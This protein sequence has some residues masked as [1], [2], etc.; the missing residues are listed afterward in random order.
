[1]N[2]QPK[3]SIVSPSYNQGIFIEAAI[4][5]VLDQKYPNFEHIII[6]GGSTDD[7]LK[8]LK[9][10]PHLIWVSEPDEGQSDAINK[11]FRLATGKYIGWLNVDDYYLPGTFSSVINAF[12]SDNSIDA[13][14]SNYRI[15][16]ARS[17]ISRELYTQN[18][19]KWMSLFYCHIPSTTL[20]FSRKIL[21][22]H[23]LIDKYFDIAM[24]MEFIAHMLYSG[25]K[26]KKINSCFAHFRRHE[27]NKS[28]DTKEVKKI[29]TREGMEIFNRYSGY[30]LPE[31]IF[32]YSFYRS[33]DYFCMLYRHVSRTL[34]I[35]IYDTG[36]ML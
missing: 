7:T 1:M 3:I 10:Y 25:Y 9:K 4:K 19:S 17:S 33:V 34:N 29:R 16:D 14:Y 27:T 11:G 21:D 24:D 32:G 15:V 6:D 13:V 20:F 5:S 35:G 28:N 22:D 12:A 18:A 8:I 31:N 2:T 23:I 26:V 30:R 36:K